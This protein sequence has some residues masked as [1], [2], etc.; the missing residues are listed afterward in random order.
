VRL[1]GATGP[2]L[3]EERDD[4]AVKQLRSATS[5]VVWCSPGER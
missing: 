1:D 2:V 3:A 5:P 4:E